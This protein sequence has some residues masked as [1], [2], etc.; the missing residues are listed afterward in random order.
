M[1][2]P[3]FVINDKQ[4]TCYCDSGKLFSECC[5]P[6]LDNNAYAKTAKQLMRSR[7]TAFCLHQFDYLVDTLY[8]SNRPQD[9]Q[10]RIESNDP[11][12]WISLRIINQS[13]NPQNNNEA[14]V[15][16]IA[17]FEENGLFYELHENSNFIKKNSRWYYTEGETIIQ[18]I[19]LKW[20]RNA[21]CWCRS[22]KKY[23]VCHH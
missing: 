15:E 10:P 20:P 21:P 13:I 9:D 8:P 1:S 2:S 3:T 22:G 5:L 6:L 19:S 4:Q 16:F 18:P 23:K 17:T 14:W 11:T 12:R 7:Y